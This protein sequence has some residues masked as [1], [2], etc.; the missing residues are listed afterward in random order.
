MKKLNQFSKN[1]LSKIKQSDNQ[2]GTATVIAVLILSLMTG[3]VALSITR[4]NNETMAVSND[5]A[6]A[7]AFTAAQASLENMTLNADAKFDDKLDL[8]TADIDEIKAALPDNFPGVN[9]N[10]SLQKVRDSEIVDATGVAFQGLKQLR[11][12]WQL[13][14]TATDQQ[15]GVQSI[16]RRR[17]FNNRIPIFQ[18]GVFAEDDVDFSQAPRFDF[19]G[20]VHSNGNL[21]MSSA[22]S[23]GLYFD[24]SITVHGEIVTDILPNGRAPNGNDNIWIKNAQLTPVNLKGN[25][26]SALSAGTGANVFADTSYFPNSA[27][28]PVVHANSNWN[29]V[30]AKFDNKLLN[31]VDKLN[32]PL[33]GSLNNDKYIPIIKRG[34]AI[35]DVANN[36]A[37]TVANPSI[38]AVTPITQPITPAT[39]DDVKTRKERFYNKVGLRISLA[40]SRIKLPGCS[41][42]AAG[43]GVR[44]DGK[45]DGSGAEPGIGEARGYQ[46]LPMRDGTVNTRINGERMYI[47]DQ[48]SWIKVEL[49][50]AGTN[51]T[52]D[53]TD[54]TK[55]ILSLGVT[56]RADLNNGYFTITSAGY[57]TSNI[58]KYSI[59]KLQ[60]F[61]IP[62]DQIRM[63]NNAGDSP[64]LTYISG[65]GPSLNFVLAQESLPGT[66]TVDKNPQ[67][68]WASL[69]ARFACSVV[70]SALCVGD[71]PAH[72]KTATINGIANRKIVPFPIMIFDPREGV[73][74]ETTTTTSPLYYNT[75]YPNGKTSLNGVMSSV[76]IDVANLRDFLND[77]SGNTP[78]T[79]ATGTTYS[80][81]KG[82][83]KGSAVPQANGWVVYL[84]DRRGDYDFDGEY[85]MEDIFAT[86]TG[87]LNTGIALTP[88]PGEDVNWNGS[89]QSEYVHE[90]P[91]YSESIAP[92]VAATVNTRFYRRVARLINGT[93]LPGVY[94]VTTPENTKGFTFASENGVYIVGNYNATGLTAFGSANT[95]TKSD[96]YLPQN[97]ANHIPASIVADSTT[98]LSKGWK[99]ANIFAA[100]Y[101]P[102]TRVPIETTYRFA[103]ITGDSLNFAPCNTDY[104]NS[105]SS[106]P[107]YTGGVHNLNRFM[108]AWTG[109][110]LNYTGSIINLYNSHNNNGAFKCCSQVYTAP[111]RNFAF[112]SSFLNPQRIPPGTPFVQTIKLTGFE[113]VND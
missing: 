13:S 41:S 56:E 30:K 102:A 6:E 38:V 84:S 23:N 67:S 65:S 66:S 17:F 93:T 92:E 45:S 28:L 54:V 5:I 37:G 85:D 3:F 106:Y 46:P 58:D 68:A 59:I 69:T 12:E 107:C 9:F 7:K 96:Y 72:F 111:N 87:V 11:D 104:T 94:D 36:G 77:L 105:G 76:D 82:A 50:A 71:D 97:D 98:V 34:K 53:T 63:S 19:G 51:S 86:S 29:T 79:P 20:R 90:A 91:Y 109:V 18:F 22:A 101:N 52:I 108:E 64:Y 61:F 21:F 74:Y 48:Q 25:E 80:A 26:G 100:P 99:D 110:R 8:D 81:A 75:L 27:I 60:R 89:L 49:V 16:L 40:D 31:R 78:R 32:L 15:T 33:G 55:D 103:A 14:V 95:P 39:E 4:S 24:S 10:Q 47:P 44:L 1:I 43:C 70:N 88:G 112:D 57:N 62:G 113:R 2:N 83:L 35:G 73:P 42:N